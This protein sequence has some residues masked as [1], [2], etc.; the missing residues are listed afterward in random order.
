MME[1]I[2]TTIPE[3]QPLPV[4]FCDE[5]SFQPLSAHSLENSYLHLCRISNLAEIHRISPASLL[6]QPYEAVVFLIACRAVRYEIFP[7]SYVM[8]IYVTI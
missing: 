1:E 8:G 3:Y 4:S 2:G 7:M 6:I 5:P